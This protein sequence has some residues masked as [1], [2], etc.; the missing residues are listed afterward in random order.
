MMDYIWLFAIAVGTG[1]LGLA[2]AFGM[3]K[4]DTKRSAGAIA[5]AF[6]A[7]IGALGLGLY[8][9]KAPAVPSQPVDTQAKQAPP[10]GGMQSQTKNGG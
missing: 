5:G 9:S 6:I 2:L 10:E 7:A 4:Q 8:V 3:L 1:L